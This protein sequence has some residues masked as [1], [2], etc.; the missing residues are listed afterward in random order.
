MSR[1]R[2]LASLTLILLSAA[3]LSAVAQ[4]ETH[5]NPTTGHPAIQLTVLHRAEY[6]YNGSNFFHCIRGEC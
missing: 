3:A 5:I 1:T 4:P 6:G 2:A